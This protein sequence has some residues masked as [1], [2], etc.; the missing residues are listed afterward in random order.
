MLRLAIVRLATVRVFTTKSRSKRTHA[1]C[2][3]YSTS[4]SVAVCHSAGFAIV[5]VHTVAHYPCTAAKPYYTSKRP[6]MREGLPSE[7]R[8][9]PPA[10]AVLEDA[11]LLLEWSCWL[12]FACTECHGK[13]A[14]VSCVWSL[15]P[16]K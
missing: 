7:S 11:V 15:D 10:G 5:Q 8:C 2:S 9:M 6:T 4:P 16:T 1:G 12:L 13:P 14:A 3:R